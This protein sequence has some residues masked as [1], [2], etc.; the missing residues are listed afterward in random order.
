MRRRDFRERSEGNLSSDSESKIRQEVA[1]VI[2]LN[3]RVVSE[4]MARVLNHRQQQGECQQ[5]RR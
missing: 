4:R 3:N 5:H 1:R 2:P